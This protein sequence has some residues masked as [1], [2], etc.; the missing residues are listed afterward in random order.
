MTARL[1]TAAEVAEIRRTT[2][3][4]LA[5]ERYRHDGPPYVRSGRRVLYP[6]DLLDA[7]LTA[8][9]VTPPPART[10]PPAVLR[11]LG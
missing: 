2:T 10:I 8:Q 7:W 4:A 5:Q 3:A 6:A 11:A 9:T 1:L